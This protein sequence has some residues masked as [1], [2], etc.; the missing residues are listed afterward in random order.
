MLRKLN[1]SF[2][3]VGKVCVAVDASVHRNADLP[4]L[5]ERTIGL[6]NM[7][8]YAQDTWRV[9]S[10]LTWTIGVRDTYNSNPLNPHQQIGRLSGSFDSISHDVNQPL[11]TV[12]QT[13]LGNLF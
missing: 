12:I 3:E 13:H 6:L 11:N 1:G 8:F 2:A 9:T 10:K 7:D 4:D 5:G